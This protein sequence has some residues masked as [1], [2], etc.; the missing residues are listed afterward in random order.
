M[1][2]KFDRNEETKVA[3]KYLGRLRKD[4]AKRH[5]FPMMVRVMEDLVALFPN[6]PS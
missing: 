4:I 1:I 3:V 5:S 2:C 6:E